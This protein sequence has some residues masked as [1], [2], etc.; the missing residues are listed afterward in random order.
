MISTPK[1]LRS[2]SDGI[3][4]Y[5]EDCAIKGLSHRTIQGKHSHLRRF[6]SWCSH[7]GVTRCKEVTMEVI[8]AYQSHLYRY[9]KAT[10]HS[11]LEKAT[12]RNNL[13]SVR[14][15]FRRLHLRGVIKHNPVALMELPKVPRQ[16]PKGYLDVDEIDLVLQQSLIQDYKGI[17]DRA[18]LEV[19]YATGIRRMELANL[20]IDDVDLKECIV[21]VRKGKGERDR[22]AP[23]AEP[24]CVWIA[25]YL[26]HVRPRLQHLTSGRALFLDNKGLR[27]RAHQLTRIVS[28]YLRRSGVRKAGA[29]NLFRHSTATLMHQNG[30][31]IRY[32]QDML[33][34]ADIS[35][36][37]IYTHVAINKLREV[38]A[39]THPA[40]LRKNAGRE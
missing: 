13:T 23:I 17:R 18:I 19:Y 12:I 3:A 1:T 8:E 26:K 38:Y 20:D 22:R 5:L 7:E 32:V 40:A 4:Y 34:H 35:T 28:K 10:D 9:R 2:L 30:A 25:I 39:D 6:L 29:C 33:G 36:T 31:D 27:Y 24:S 14:M 37:Q 21:T 15:L 11:P 16:L